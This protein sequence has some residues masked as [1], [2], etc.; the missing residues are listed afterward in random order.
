MAAVDATGNAIFDTFLHYAL[1]LGA[2]FQLVC[3]FAVVFIPQSD[4]EQEEHEECAQAEQNGNSKHHHDANK[5]KVR[6]E[7]GKKKLR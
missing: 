6:Q 5:V 4:D 3:I 1:F 2:I 7:R